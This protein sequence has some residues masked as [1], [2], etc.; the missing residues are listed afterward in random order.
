M[1]PRILVFML[2]LLVLCA[3]SI[4]FASQETVNAPLN[5]AQCHNF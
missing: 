4:S 1:K 2:R 3:L 5:C